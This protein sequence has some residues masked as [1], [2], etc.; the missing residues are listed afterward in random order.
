[1]TEVQGLY[2]P[3]LLAVESNGCTCSGHEKNMVCQPWRP[4]SGTGEMRQVRNWLLRAVLDKRCYSPCKPAPATMPTVVPNRRSSCLLGLQLLFWHLVQA[5]GILTHHCRIK[6]DTSA[7]LLIAWCIREVPVPSANTHVA[8]MSWIRECFAREGRR[9][10]YRQVRSS[11]RQVLAALVL[12]G[13]PQTQ[14]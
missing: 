13:D 9:S 2:R 1:M 11:C 7:A 5:A 6:A 8:A 4:A 14:S 3:C 10:S 12:S